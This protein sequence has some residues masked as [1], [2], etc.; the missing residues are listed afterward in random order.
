MKKQITLFKVSL[1]T[2]CLMAIHQSQA[3]FTFGDPKS[4]AGALSISGYVRGYY[5]NKDYGYEASDNKIQFDAVQ[6]KLNYDSVQFFGKLEY[7]CYQYDTL[8]DFSIL[9]D[10]YTGYKIDNQNTLTVGIQPIP[11]GPSRFWE[12]SLYGGINNTVGLEDTHNLGVNLHWEWPSSKTKIDA[13]YFL[14]D[15]GHYTGSSKDAARYT[16]NLVSTDVNGSM[17]E[18]H[19]WIGRVMQEL[20]LNIDDF[21]INVGA[22]YWYSDIENE[23]LNKDGH[24]KAWAVFST[25]NYKDLSL[26]LTGGKTQMSNANRGQPNIS[27]LGSYDS[28]YFVANNA[29]FYTADLSYKLKP[30]SNGLSFSP[31]VMHSSYDKQLNSAKNSQ[32]NIAGL[33]I[34]YKNWSLTAEYIVSKNDPFIGGDQNSLGLGDDNEWKKL[35]NFTLFYHF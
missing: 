22:S 20:P 34:D 29:N 27:I 15:G 19:M 2:V 1:S 5:Q 17:Q 11:F 23:T 31:Y 12:S 18:K 16:A 14:Q 9:V 8:C 13:A 30:L 33:N 28:E 35:M 21:N 7:R 26:T 24:R 3:A 10:G 25:L 6:L 4:E 32:R